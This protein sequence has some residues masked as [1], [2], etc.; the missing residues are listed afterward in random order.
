MLTTFILKNDDYVTSGTDIRFFLPIK[1]PLK[2]IYED[3]PDAVKLADTVCKY[4]NKS[5]MKLCGF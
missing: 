2:G 4:L 1:N 5:S 3:F